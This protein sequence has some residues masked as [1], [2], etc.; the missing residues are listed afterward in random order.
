MSE[1]ESWQCDEHVKARNLYW[2][3]H[4]EELWRR[5]TAAGAR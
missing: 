5:M 1:H 2:S 4:A 3:F